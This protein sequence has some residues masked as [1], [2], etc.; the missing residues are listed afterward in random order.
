MSAECVI[1][2]CTVVFWLRLYLS[3]KHQDQVLREFTMVS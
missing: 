2:G 3:R 1:T